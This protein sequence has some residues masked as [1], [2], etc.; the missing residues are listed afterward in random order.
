M[1]YSKVFYSEDE[2]IK[3]QKGHTCEM[4][5]DEPRRGIH[6]LTPSL[7]LLPSTFSESENSLEGIPLC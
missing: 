4:K 2:E 1:A 3:V 6:L 5:L 7:P